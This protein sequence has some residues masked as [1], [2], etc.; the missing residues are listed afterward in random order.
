[1]TRPTPPDANVY[2]VAD[3]R[4]VRLPKELVPDWVAADSVIDVQVV[5]P[6]KTG[7]VVPFPVERAVGAID[8]YPTPDDTMHLMTRVPIEATVVLPPRW[9]QVDRGGYEQARRE[10]EG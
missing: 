1:V 8:H 4:F 7:P 2:F 5:T 10:I 9:K 3:A 6:G